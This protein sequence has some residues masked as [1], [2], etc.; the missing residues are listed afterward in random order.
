MAKPSQSKAK[1]GKAAKGPGKNRDGASHHSMNPTRPKDS[2]KVISPQD[3]DYSPVPNIRP[4][5]N[6][7]PDGDRWSKL[8]SNQDL[9]TNHL[10]LFPKFQLETITFNCRL[11]G[12]L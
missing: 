3:Y 10:V 7:R 4:G 9:F 5:P 2:V 1:V 11:L 6:Y 8:I 12:I